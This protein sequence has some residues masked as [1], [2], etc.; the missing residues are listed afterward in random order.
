MHIYMYIYI[1]V[2]M[3]VCKYVCRYACRYVS[4]YI[5]VYICIYLCCETAEVLHHLL[6]NP[7]P[8]QVLPTLPEAVGHCRGQY[9]KVPHS[10]HFLPMTS[11]YVNTGAGAHAECIEPH[12]LALC[13]ALPTKQHPNP[14]TGVHH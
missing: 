7:S 4:M 5:F 13:L 8:T 10:A 12:V 1:Y 6:P 14:K 2:S 11:C 9:I 3:Y